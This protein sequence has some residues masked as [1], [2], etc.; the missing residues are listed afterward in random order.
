MTAVSSGNSAGLLYCIAL[1]LF[2]FSQ[3]L[4]CGDLAIPIILKTGLGGLGAALG[5]PAPPAAPELEESVIVYS[6][7]AT[8]DRRPKELAMNQSLGKSYPNAGARLIRVTCH[9]SISAGG[10]I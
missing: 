6:A 9:E 10:A 1:V 5:W 7:A 2:A 4:D 8:R 3:L